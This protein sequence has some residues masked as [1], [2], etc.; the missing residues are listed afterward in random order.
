MIYYLMK[1]MIHLQQHKKRKKISWWMIV[2]FI[3]VLL[4]IISQSDTVRRTFS[5]GAISVA[6]PLW[7]IQNS[8]GVGGYSTKL[9]SKKDILLLNEK[10]QAE[11]TLLRVQFL[12]RKLL[13]QENV[14]L[15]EILGRQLEETTSLLGV[16][17][18]KPSRS[19]YDT[20]IID[21]GLR[22]GISKGDIVMAYG[23]VAIGRIDEVYN[24]SSRVKLFSSPGEEIDVLV[25]VSN[26]AA[27][28]EGVGNGNFLLKLP[29][30]VDV[31]E[32]DIVSFPSLSPRLAGVVELIQV[33]PSGSFQQILFKSPINMHELK[34]IEVILS[35]EL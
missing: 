6:E 17:L 16:V 35:G 19:L 29:Q 32:G 14:E 1:M 4:L 9:L 28:A 25:G 26:I 34:W 23:D 27:T 7:E 30:G 24:D 11:V 5:G 20:L 13:E 3:G 10:L 33:E 21:I 18:I 2:L 15:K 8:L 12:S 22:D 31:A